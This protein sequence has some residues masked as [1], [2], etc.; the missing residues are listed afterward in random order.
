MVEVTIVMGPEGFQ[1]LGPD[2]A[3]ML[4]R[5]WL[6]RSLKQQCGIV[7]ALNYG[8]QMVSILCFIRR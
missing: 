3:A 5:G 2:K 8:G 6:W 4:E 1:R 7:M